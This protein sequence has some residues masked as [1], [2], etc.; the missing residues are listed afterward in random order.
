MRETNATDY[1]IKKLD[2]Q[3]K[4]IADDIVKG[5]LPE[6]MYKRQAGVLHGL[7]YAIDLITYTVDQIANDKELDSNE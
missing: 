3:Y 4:R 7:Q 2:K 6:I 1:L 5:D